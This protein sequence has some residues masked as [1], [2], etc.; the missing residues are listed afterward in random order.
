MNLTWISRV[1]FSRLGIVRAGYANRYA[2]NYETVERKRTARLDCRFCVLHGGVLA[3]S[4]GICTSV[5]RIAKPHDASCRLATRARYIVHGLVFVLP[6]SFVQ[7]QIAHLCRVFA[8]LVLG[9]Y[10]LRFTGCRHHISLHWSKHRPRN[11]Y[12][13]LL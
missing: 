3:S 5:H 6:K 10:L 2:Q 4:F 11:P 8:L 13:Q 7:G 1:R 12:T 9:R